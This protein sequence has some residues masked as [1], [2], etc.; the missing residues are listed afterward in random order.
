MLFRSRRGQQRQRGDRRRAGRH[1]AGWAS[2]Y[3]VT[4]QTEQFA[5][6][7]ESE[8]APCVLRNLSVFGAGVELSGRDATVGDRVVLDLQLA[9]RRPASIQVAGEIRH[10]AP[11]DD[12]H[13]VAGVE[14]LE[15]GDLERALLLRLVRNLQSNVREL[16]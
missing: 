6:R 12:G 4:N 7:D 14:F 10:T 5:F 2:R 16:A 11:A 9:E 3:L 1:T 15:V 8:Y 13:V